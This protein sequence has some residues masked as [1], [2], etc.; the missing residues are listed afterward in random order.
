MIFIHVPRKNRLEHL[1]GTYCSFLEFPGTLLINSFKIFPAVSA[2]TPRSAMCSQSMRNILMVTQGADKRGLILPFLC[3]ILNKHSA[4][5]KGSVLQQASWPVSLTK[6]VNGS[7]VPYKVEWKE[8]QALHLLELHMHAC[9]E[10]SL[11]GPPCKV[12]H[13]P[14]PWGVFTPP[15]FPC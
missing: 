13:V 1:Q 14:R 12:K 6:V 10:G 15:I 5:D 3:I 2:A 9:T 4:W 7:E 8:M 11:V